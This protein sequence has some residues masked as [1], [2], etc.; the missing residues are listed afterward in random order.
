MQNKSPESFHKNQVR[1]EHII[2]AAL[3]LFS[4]KGF[5]NTRVDEIAEK[6]EVNKALIYYHFESKEALLNHLLEGFFAGIK[7][8]AMNFINNSI[9]KAI[10][11]GELDILPDRIRFT[12]DAAAAG[13]MDNMQLYYEE[14]LDYFLD[15]RDT[16]RLMLAESLKRDRKQ[17]DLFHFIEFMEQKESNP[18]YQTIRDAD[19]D[20]T[21]TND[22]MIS[23]FF[24]GVLPMLNMAAYF[25]D[26]IKA[27]SM[28]EKE[29]RSDFF[30]VCMS[31][32]PFPIQGRDL[33]ISI[34]GSASIS[35]K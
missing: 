33:I 12:D 5:E 13:F 4:E 20:F 9:V 14:L 27:C 11:S 24:Y 6:A 23:K 19:D 18:I 30:R 7:M 28:S 17:M 21:Y 10:Q 1:R 31:I 34:D 2:E 26:Y 16:V 3:S 15:N 25:D 32:R 35:D 22:M 8:K 29:L